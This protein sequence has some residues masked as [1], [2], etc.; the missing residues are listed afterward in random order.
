MTKEVT[1][2]S[3]L[4]R[5]GYC[6]L[7]WFRSRKGIQGKGKELQEGIQKHKFLEVGLTTIAHEDVVSDDAKKGIFSYTSVTITLA[8]LSIVAILSGFLGIDLAAILVILAL[9]WSLAGCYLLYLMLKSQEISE[10]LRKEHG[11][12]PGKIDYSDSKEADSL[13]SKKYML[14]G[15]PDFIIEKA[16]VKIPVEV[17]TGRVPR[18]PHFSHIL[19]LAGYCLLMEDIYGTSP[20]YGIVEYE[21][22]QQHRI[23]FTDDLKKTVIEKLTL[24]KAIE[25]GEK[26]AHRNHNRQGKCRFCSRRV[27]CPESLA[28][29]DGRSGRKRKDQQ[30][31]NQEKKGNDSSDKK[32][33]EKKE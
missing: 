32:D 22:K 13:F 17:K 16:G 9:L 8:L 30:P 12:P 25:R 1:T 21:S 19:Q 7:S 33:Q 2:C 29:D 26:E 24:I 31:K 20:P 14:S 11:V 6:P 5:F 4:E 28:K 15:K 27:G 3:E 18:G 23:D 10:E